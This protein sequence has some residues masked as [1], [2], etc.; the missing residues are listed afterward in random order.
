M[1]RRTKRFLIVSAALLAL[2]A[3][4]LVEE[5]VRGVRALH[6]WQ[7]EMRAR[8]EKLTVAELVTPPPA[9]PAC[10]ILSPQEAF[11]QIAIA[12]SFS[13]APP[14]MQYVAPG[15]AQAIWQTNK[16]R[17]ERRPTNNSWGEVANSLQ[18]ILPA[19]EKLRGDL[20][21]QAFVVRLDYEQGFTLLLPHLARYK[22]L[23]ISL[24][25]AT[26][27]ALR[28]QRLDL[29]TENLVAL[30][31]LID[32]S[33]D[34]GLLINELVRDA[35]AAIGVSVLW[36]ALQADAWS[37]AQLAAIQVAWQRPD[38][39]RGMAHA[40]EVERAVSSLFFDRSRYSMGKLFAVM[41]SAGLSPVGAPDTAALNA[42]LGWLAEAFQPVVQMGIRF[43]HLTGLAVWRVAWME[44]DQLRHQQVLQQAIDRM[45]RSVSERYF[46]ALSKTDDEDFLTLWEPSPALPSG[47]D[48]TRYWITRHLLPA[49]D[50]IQ[51]KASMTEA[52]RELAVAA[53]AIKRYQLRH[54]RLPDNLEALVPEFLSALPR[55]WFAG[56]PLHFAPRGDAS[57]L[58]YSV[59]ADGVD[60]GGDARPK[61][62]AAKPTFVRGRDLVWPQPAS[63][64]EIAAFEAKR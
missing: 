9:N 58:L 56:A 8:G 34:E 62:P 46:P 5:R 29:A 35:I 26:L 30:P 52:Q 64:A 50:K 53:I 41:E 60:D 19:I 17:S 49:L 22:G 39:M 47:W 13:D 23:A 11:S 54:G 61:D 48:R 40:F 37:D 36:E 44:Q 12:S 7:E 3:G 63:A 14:A 6:S 27:L 55:D 25:G 33:K 38:F 21:N 43:K 2:A 10:R 24:R 59:G 28:Q 57:F 31:A 1:S 45:R 20:T 16:W 51:Q 18:P 4:F 32:L 15:K 42:Q